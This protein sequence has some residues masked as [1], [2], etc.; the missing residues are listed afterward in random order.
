[1][2]ITRFVLLVA[3]FI[4]TVA[5][6]FQQVFTPRRGGGS[7]LAGFIAVLGGALAFLIISGLWTF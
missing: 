5:G 3:A 4:V 1:M 2:S 6:L 7:T